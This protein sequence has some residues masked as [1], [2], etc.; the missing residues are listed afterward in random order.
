MGGSMFQIG[1]NT[2]HTWLGVASVNSCAKPLSSWGLRTCGHGPTR[3]ITRELAC[4]LA[5]DADKRC[6]MLHMSFRSI[7]SH[8]GTPV[9]PVP[10]RNK[11]A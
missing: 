11:V 4:A 7:R 2:L 6:L 9:G 5:H 8:L 10:A 3:D 1:T